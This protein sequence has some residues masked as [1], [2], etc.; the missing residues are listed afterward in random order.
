MSQF[1]SVF[2]SPTVTAWS[3]LKYMGK[4]LASSKYQ[5]FAFGFCK[6]E[7]K[8]YHISHFIYFLYE[9]YFF[10]L[11]QSSDSSVDHFIVKSCIHPRPVYYS[12]EL[13]KKLG[14]PNVGWDIPSITGQEFHTRSSMGL[15]T[16]T[17]HSIKHNCREN[18]GKKG[19]FPCLR[20]TS[21]TPYIG[22]I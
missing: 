11:T 22:W 14:K 10:Y 13:P 19:S 12:E 4:N 1:F 3:A 7:R 15:N 20:T 5:S 6:I 21:L 9:Y 18:H 2:M 16:R 8:Y 17:R